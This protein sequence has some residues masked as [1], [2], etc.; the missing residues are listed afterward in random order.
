[1]I[2]GHRIKP[3]DHLIMHHS[4][5]PEFINLTDLEVQDW[6]DRTGA[7]RGYKGKSRSFHMH[8]SR[9][10]ETFSQAQFALRQYTKDGN[11]YGWR[12]TVLM[13]K[14]FE[15]VAWHAGNWNINQRSI[16]I[17]TCGNFVNKK[18]P[19]KALMLVADYFRE[20]D[21][22]IG[23][24]MK[25]MGHRQFS[26]TACPGL[27]LDQLKTIIDMMNN[28]TKWNN[29]LFPAPKPEPKPEP[30][31][32]PVDP[33]FNG[34]TPKVQTF[35]P[36]ISFNLYNIKTGEAVK[37]YEAFTEVVVHYEKNG[38]LMT[39]YSMDGKFPTAFKLSELSYVPEKVQEVVS[40]LKDTSVETGYEL[41]SQTGLEQVVSTPEVE[42]VE[43]P[44]EVIEA[45]EEFEN[46]FSFEDVENIAKRSTKDYAAPIGAVTALVVALLKWVF[47][48]MPD[49][50]LT[51]IAGITPFVTNFVLHE[52]YHWSDRIQGE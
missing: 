2:D 51:A 3:V 31:V 23:G 17:E 48:S 8:P 45:R 6:F 36:P 35:K 19:N 41:E 37:G 42:K 30:I 46:N 4:V 16:G 1:M 29:A 12:L 38:W 40:P 25:V 13:K 50:V 24:I 10:K 26:A 49:G 11:K 32:K 43:I 22:S 44:Q 21:K 18:L 52:Y 27:I 14:P 47:P 34:W 7:G 39:R 28:P 33:I 20:H 5:G 9:N 15:N